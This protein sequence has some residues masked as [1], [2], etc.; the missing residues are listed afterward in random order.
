MNAQA[1]NQMNG[2]Y[3]VPGI[4]L[5]C[6]VLGSGYNLGVSYSPHTPCASPEERTDLAAQKA[7]LKAL[8]L[9]SKP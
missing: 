5:N 8:H 3:V 2:S 9:P 4:V 7:N 1:L 6:R